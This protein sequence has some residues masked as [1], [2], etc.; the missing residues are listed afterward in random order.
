MEN[1][2]KLGAKSLSRDQQKQVRGGLQRLVCACGDG[3]G[4]ICMCNLSACMGDAISVC[5]GTGQSYCSGS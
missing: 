3:T 1:L 2:E 4:F 5:A